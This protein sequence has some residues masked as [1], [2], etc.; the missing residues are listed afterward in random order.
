MTIA[1]ASCWQRFIEAFGIVADGWSE[2][3]P[4]PFRPLSEAG[5]ER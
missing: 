3:A 2:H 5:P 4:A 1:F